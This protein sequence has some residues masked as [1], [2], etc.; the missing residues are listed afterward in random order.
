MNR[1]VIKSSIGNFVVIDDS[2]F[3][4]KIEQSTEEPSNLSALALE[5]QS[6]LDEYLKHQRNIFELPYQLT[7]TV[8][9]KAIWSALSEVPFGTTL[10]YGELANR[11]GYPKAYRAVGTA[12]KSNPLP[13]IIPCHRIVKSNHK[14]GEYVLGKELKEQLI[15]LEKHG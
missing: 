3:I 5:F 1:S 9:Q 15:C 10:T 4:L 11:A 13:L 8:F 12:C 14:Y 6:Q 7:G 2:N